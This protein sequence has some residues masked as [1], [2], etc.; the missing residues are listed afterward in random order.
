MKRGKESMNL[1]EA[2]SVRKSVREF[3]KREIEEAFVEVL[4]RFTRELQP[5]F[6]EIPYE[7]VF[8][9]AK[10]EKPVKK[11]RFSVDAPYYISFLSEDTREGQINAGFLMEQ[12]VLFLT[13][14]GIAT[15]YQGNIS[16]SNSGKREKKELIVVAAG[17]PVHYLYRDENSIKR[18]PLAKQCLFKEEASRNVMLI[19]KAANLAPSAMNNQPWRFVVYS[20]RIHV[21]T[22]KETL[23]SKTIGCSKFIDTGIAL[24]HMAIA[25][26]ELWLDTEWKISE[27]IQ[28]QNFKSN[29]YTITM[30][31]R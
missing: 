17:Y 15:C 9:D 19:L 7:I 12:I 22:Q 4:E 23:I 16:F 2:I 5:V 3:E 26:E 27:N 6:P 25:A 31:I 29:H 14:R 10:E 18:I 8:H 11:G 28:N 20:N 24:A 1:Y 30:M 21:M 13:C